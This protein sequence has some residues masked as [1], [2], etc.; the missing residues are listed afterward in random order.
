MIALSFEVPSADIDAIKSQI[1]RL[2]SELGKT[3]KES[4]RMAALY[5][6]TALRP[7][8]KLS[9]K[10]RPIVR[11][12]DKRAGIDGRVAV[13]GV[14]KYTRNGATK[15]VPIYR[16]GEFG[17]IK[18]KSKTTAEWLERD[19][20]T[21]EVH[22]M[23]WNTGT[24]EFDIPGIAQSKK[25]I[26][27]RRGTARDSWTWAQMRLFGHGP[28]AMNP[29]TYRPSVSVEKSETDLFSYSVK[30]YNYLDYITSAMRSGGRAD[31]ST[32]MSRAANKMRS[33]IEKRIA[34]AIQ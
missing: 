23:Q 24:S 5:V 11:N 7:S 29:K 8:T 33:V 1:A 34:G 13:F 27:G 4:V 12:P 28:R 9:A 25:R 2:Q 6:L 20:M 10:L 30:I 3:T 14:N 32:A 17:K 15:F 16:A 26:I 19:R 21:G 18:F 31:V 22:R